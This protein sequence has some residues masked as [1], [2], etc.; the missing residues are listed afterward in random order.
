[1][2]V[3]QNRAILHAIAAIAFAVAMALPATATAVETD[4][5]KARSP[6]VV[7][8]LADDAGYGDYSFVGNTNLSTPA[9]DSLARDGAVLSQFFVQPVCSPTRA[10]LLTGRY[11]PRSGQPQVHATGGQWRRRPLAF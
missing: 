3:S 9:I 11:A 10:E 6:N 1:M 4:P 7:V 5:T 8:I 2:P